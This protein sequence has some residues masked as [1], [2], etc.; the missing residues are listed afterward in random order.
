MLLMG[1]FLY[2]R[3][4][5]MDAVGLLDTPPLLIIFVAIETLCQLPSP[6]FG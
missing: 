2:A 1:Q 6:V 4:V 3:V 5:F